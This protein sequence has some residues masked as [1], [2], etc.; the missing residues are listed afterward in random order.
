MPTIK[1]QVQEF[2]EAVGY[3]RLWILG[4]TEIAE[5][6]CSSVGEAQPLNWTE[7]EQWAF[8][9]LKKA[10]VSAPALAL[11]DVRKPFHLYV[12]EVRGIAKGVLTQT[13]GPWKRPV[14]YLRD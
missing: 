2:L 13:L 11:P 7:M 1:K 9:E 6:L 8:E 5:P 12:S 14:A 4:F 3:C 10:L